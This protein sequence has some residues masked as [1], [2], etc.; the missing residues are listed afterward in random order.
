MDFSKNVNIELKDLKT[1]IKYDKFLTI[2][3]N[4]ISKIYNYSDIL[5]QNSINSG[6]IS[7]KII[8]KD[9]IDFNGF[10]SGFTFP[11]KK[12]NKEIN[13]LDFYGNINKDSVA[14]LF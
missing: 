10:F 1:T 9:N 6:N 13:S 8:N 5:K 7:L 4:D 11:I 2:N 14:N 3:V 12:D